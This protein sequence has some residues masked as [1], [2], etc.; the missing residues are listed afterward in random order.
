MAIDSNANILENAD[1][2]LNHYNDYDVNFMAYDTDSL[3]SNIRIDKGFNI[4]HHNSRSILAEGKMEEY[5]VLLETIGNPFHILAFSETWL[6]EENVNNINFDGYEHIYLTRPTD[7]GGLSFFVKSGLD[8]IVC[9]N[10]NIMLPFMESIF[11]E[12]TFNQKQ[13]M[14]GLIYRVPN[15]NINN[16]IDTLN[17]LIEPLKNKYEVILMGDFNIDLLQDNNCSRKLKNMTQSNYLVP[18][19][20]EATRVASIFRNGENHLTETL[21]DNIF[22]NTSTEFKSGLIYSSISD[23]YPV[24]SIINEGNLP[25]QGEIPKTIKTRQIDEFKIRKFKSALQRSFINSIRNIN[26]A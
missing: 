17:N 14:I 1:P 20:L 3:K 15:T 9:N 26:D 11:I 6:K 24:F 2:D 21:I 25:S 4:M 16:F 12:V 13:Y 23:H 8:Y 18:T 7:G 10:M 19:I 22:I 5:E